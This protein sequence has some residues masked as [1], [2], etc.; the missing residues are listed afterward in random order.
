MRVIRRSST[1]AAS[2]EQWVEQHVLDRKEGLNEMH[3][4]RLV[5]VQCLRTLDI[6]AT[7]F[8][9]GRLFV[10]LKLSR[11]NLISS[12]IYTNRQAS[13]VHI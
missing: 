8:G 7:K 3:E 5:I 6:S 12:L 13:S 2:A 10:I 9:E 4:V 1:D 11:T